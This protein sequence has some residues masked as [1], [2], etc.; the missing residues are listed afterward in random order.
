MAQRGTAGAPQSVA[1]GLGD[2]LRD[3][4]STMTAP[5]AVQHAPLLMKLQASVLDLYHKVTGMATPPGMGG[6]PS[7]AGPQMGAAAPGAQGGPNVA[8]L[9]GGMQ[10]PSA[11]ASVGGGMAS[12][13]TAERLRQLVSM[14][15][16]GGSG[17]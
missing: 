7:G 6:A 9:M 13:T 3:L 10:G 8:A 15:A 17:T 2:V 14:A 16:S 4:S 5:D 11:A 1:E 12:G